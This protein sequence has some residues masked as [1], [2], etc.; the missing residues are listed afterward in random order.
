MDELSP[1][2]IFFDGG[3]AQQMRD[4]LRVDEEEKGMT[5]DQVGSVAANR[6]YD[7]TGTTPLRPTARWELRLDPTFSSECNA[8]DV[9]DFKS[10]T[11][12]NVVAD[13]TNAPL[14]RGLVSKYPQTAEFGCEL[15]RFS[16]RWD[17]ASAQ[18]MLRVRLRDSRVCKAAPLNLTENTFQG[19]IED[20][21]ATKN[22]EP[23]DVFFEAEIPLFEAE[24]PNSVIVRIKD[25]SFNTTTLPMP[26]GP[27]VVATTDGTEFEIYW[28]GLKVDNHAPFA[29]RAHLNIVVP[30]V[31]LPDGTDVYL[32]TAYAA[33]LPLDNATTIAGDRVATFL[34]AYGAS[35]AGVRRTQEVVESHKYITASSNTRVLCACTDGA[36]DTPC[37]SAASENSW[38]KFDLGVA[39]HVKGIELVAWREGTSSPNPPPTPPPS[40]PPSP[41]PSPPR[42]PLPRV[43]SP[44]PSP[45]APPPFCS[46]ASENNCTVNF[47]DHTD[48]GVCDGIATT[49][50]E[51]SLNSADPLRVLDSRCS[52]TAGWSRSTTVAWT[53][54]RLSVH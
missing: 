14:E 29:A 7:G 13:F 24:V 23:I 2:R 34:Y 9:A 54:R 41:P 17:A 30:N 5:A 10:R 16:V 44:S 48:D 39:S 15:W 4:E 35:S 22:G 25:S 46:Y 20:Y 45:R 36:A 47:I 21:V 40:L 37:I 18:C 19:L 12:A 43:L 11:F 53:P 27:S 52:Q 31:F 28:N 50:F 51:R 42:S 1:S 6:L 3:M 33:F 26:H 32:Y 49:T 8:S 38:I